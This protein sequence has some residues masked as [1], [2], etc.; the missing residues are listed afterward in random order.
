MQAPHFK[1]VDEMVEKFQHMS[2]KKKLWFTFTGFAVIILLLLYGLQVVSLPAFYEGSRKGEAL[3]AANYIMSHYPAKNNAEFSL[4]MEREAFRRDVG[5]LV[6]DFDRKL[7]YAIDSNGGGVLDMLDSNNAQRVW[8]APPSNESDNSVTFRR[9]G[10]AYGALDND[11]NYPNPLAPAIR[12][13]A[14]GTDKISYLIKNPRLGFTTLLYAQQVKDAGDHVY[15]FVTAGLDPIDATVNV[16]K[17]QL[18]GITF[19][20]LILASA[21]A[22]YFSRNISKPITRLTEAAEEMA[23][24]NL[25]VTFE[26]S[27]FE[28]ISQLAGSLNYAVAE[29]SKT[30]RLRK[31]LIANLSHDLRTPLT[32]ITA[33]GE[34]I[35]DLSG[36]NPAKRTEHL[37]VIVD[38]SNRLS[39]L[40][41]DILAYSR[42]EA[43]V[44]KLKKEAFDLSHCLRS[45]LSVYHIMEERE[46]YRFVTDIEEGVWVFAD[47]AQTEQVFN[48]L[49]SNAL[50]HTGED[51]TVYVSLKKE[52]GEAVCRIR[53]T[54]KGI[55]PEE[56]NAIWERYYKGKTKNRRDKLGSGLGLS[57]VKGILELHKAKFGV[58]SA[59]N[60]GSTF[61]FSLPL[62]LTNLS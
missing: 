44:V 50:N 18:V 4:L 16:L 52:A 19:L 37:Q 55:A 11:T 56:Q 33:Y 2:I 17:Q 36:D 24:G 42:L 28:E 61:W 8:Y 27:G 48:N 13:L 5:L 25:H 58:D 51:K 47:L 21:M 3:R 32:M 54:G 59:V 26:E 6:L 12:E 53:D 43:G 15:V 40:V 30:D 29:I 39:N 10:A 35:R 9:S 31:D 20:L 22:Y 7:Y 46:Q 41:T 1:T 23:R 60:A 38:E 45:V 57:I 62:D 14:A 34:M 49:L